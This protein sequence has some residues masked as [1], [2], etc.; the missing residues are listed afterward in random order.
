MT[1]KS[2]RRIARFYTLK[3][4]YYCACFSYRQNS[5]VDVI[6]VKKRSAA[7]YFG[8]EWS[9]RNVVSLCVWYQ[10]Y[11]DEVTASLT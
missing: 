2:Y 10:L 11:M 9:R 4:I 6:T 5:A 3:R 8:L 1:C 7:T